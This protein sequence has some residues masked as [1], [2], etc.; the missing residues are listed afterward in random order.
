MRYEQRKNIVTTT[1]VN[2][3][4]NNENTERN[5]GNTETKTENFRTKI[6]NLMTEH[7]LLKKQHVLLL[8]RDHDSSEQRTKEI[9]FSTITQLAEQYV[10]LDE[11][12]DDT[13]VSQVA[14]KSAFTIEHETTL[15][16][17]SEKLS[18]MQGD[19]QIDVARL[20][21]MTKYMVQATTESNYAVEKHSVFGKFQSKTNILIFTFDSSVKY[22]TRL[23]D[24][25]C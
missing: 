20:A 15:P 11:P 16:E 9:I 19:T 14:E 22:L 3:E 12:I 23:F 25:K 4:R 6:K 10:K 8:R 7:A 17:S 1:F 24:K 21:A 2:T 18:A 13:I 5:N